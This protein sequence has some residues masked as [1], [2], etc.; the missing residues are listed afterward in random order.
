MPPTKNHWYFGA[1]LAVLLL[2]I[3]AGLR[4]L[5][6]ILLAPVFLSSFGFFVLGGLVYYAIQSDRESQP[7]PASRQRRAIRPLRFTQSAAW[8][9][10]LDGNPT[11]STH[12]PIHPDASPE[13]NNIWNRFLGLIIQHFV[14]PWYDRISPSPAFPYA[15]D[16]VI[17]DAVQEV[18]RRA[19][20]VDWPSVMVSKVLP[21]L[22][23][24][25]QHYRSVEHHT[26]T[27]PLLPLPLPNRPHKAFSD[28]HLSSSAIEE[29][30]RQTLS[31]IVSQAVPEKDQTPVSMT[32]VRE[33]LL[34][35]VVTPMLT[36]ICEADFWNRQIDEH[37][38][39]YLHEQQQVD[40]FLSALS[41]LPAS[42]SS[43][44]L[45]P[46]STRKNRNPASINADSTP[47]Q[48]DVFL[49][50][51]RKLKSLGEARRLRADVERELRV[52]KVAF[53][54]D[55]R[56]VA[57]GYGPKGKDGE[58][59][60]RRNR[61]YVERLEKARMDIDTRIDMLSGDSKQQHH[62]KTVSIE[63]HSDGN[64]TL[65]TILLDPS[66]LAYWLEHM[67]RRQRSRL[68][69]YWLTV[70]GFKDPLEVAGI[71]GPSPDRSSA[72]DTVHE[73]V[74]FLY[75]T[76]FADPSSA[77]IEI[78]P[79]YKEIIEHGA[80]AS[81]LDA[82]EITKIK[83]AIYSSQK[84]VYEQM[85]E[86]DWNTFRKGELFRKAVGDLQRSGFSTKSMSEEKHASRQVSIDNPEP[87]TIP[88][89][90]HTPE[91]KPPRKRQTIPEAS[92]SLL[93]LLP[94]TSNT[95]LASPLP[96]ASRKLG[97]RERNLVPPAPLLSAAAPPSAPSLHLTDVRVAS[98]PP[99]LRSYSDSTQKLS[100][101]KLVGTNVTGR[102]GSAGDVEHLQSQLQHQLQLPYSPSSPRSPSPHHT[103][104]LL[105]S[106]RL[107]SPAMTSAPLDAPLPTARRSSQLDF[108][109]NSAGEEPERSKLFGDDDYDDRENEEDTRRME[110]IQTA[111]S[112]IIADDAGDA[113]TQQTR[114]GKR[115]AFE[116]PAELNERD[117]WSSMILPDNSAKE[118]KIRKTR[119]AEDM[120]DRSSPLSPK[121]PRVV[122]SGE[123]HQPRRRESTLLFDDTLPEDDEVSIS[124]SNDDE[125]S[126]DLFDSSIIPTPGDL[127]LSSTI[128]RLGASLTGLGEQ[129]TL[130][131]SL[132]GRAELTGNQK[133]L[134]ILRR[135]H[136]SV[137]R[138]IRAKEWQKREFTRQEEENRLVPGRTR[139]DI[140]SA[141]VCDDADG[142]ANSAVG[143]GAKQVVR[144]T[145]RVSQVS[146]GQAI[147]GWV[148]TR[149]YN[150]FWEMDKSLR[151]WASARGEIGVIDTLKRVEIPKKRIVGLGSISSGFVESR[152]AALEKYL[153]GLLASSS[154][155]DSYIFRAFISLTP[156]V[157]NGSSSLFNG[158][159]SS[160]AP[161][162]PH[163]VL[164]SLYKTISPGGA[165]DDFNDAT[166][167]TDFMYSG[168][169]R[170]IND[171]GGMVGLGLGYPSS[172]NSD[173]ESVAGAPLGEG[174]TSFTAPICDLFIEMFDLTEKEW[175]RRQAIVIILQQFLGGTIERKV[176]EALRLVTSPSSLGKSL[177]ALQDAL[178]PSG[179]RRPPA[180]PRTE[181]EK[182]ETRS[183]AGK[184]LGLV[185][186]E[187]VAN[188]MGR[189]NA[190]RAAR[191]VF[192]T[193]QDER[194]NQHLVLCVMDVEYAPTIW[195]LTWRVCQ[196]HPAALV[197]Y[198]R[199]ISTKME[200]RAFYD[201]MVNWVNEGADGDWSPSH[202]SDAQRESI[203]YLCLFLVMILVFWQ[204]KIAYW[205]DKKRFR[206]IATG[207]IKEKRVWRTIPVPILWPFKILTVLYHELS[208]AMVG[209]CTIWWKQWSHG[210]PQGYTRGYILFIMVDKYEGGLTAFG[211]DIEP[212]Y[213]LTLPAV[214]AAYSVAGFYLLDVL[215]S[216]HVGISSMSL[217]RSKFGALSLICLTVL[218]VI[219]CMIVRAKSAITH[220][221][222]H[223]RAWCLR[224]IFCNPGKAKSEDE[225][226]EYARETRNQE[227]DYRHEQD[228]EGPT[229]HDLHASQDII[230]ACSV[231]VDILLWAAWNWDD[232]IY[233]RLV[234]LFM[235]LMSALY[236][237]WDIA[238]D[239]IKYAKVAQSDATLMAQAYNKKIEKHNNKHPNHPR[240]MRGTTF[241]A[242][243]WLMA[244]LVLIVAVLVG[245]YFC[246]RLT[247]VE[248]AIESREFLP[249][250]FHYGPA[251]LESDISGVSDAVSGEVSS[252]VAS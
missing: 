25:L 82:S 64:V 47:S 249:A 237:V 13:L 89:S 44:S 116:S 214:A 2:A 195:G 104:R 59:E 150:E 65:Y 168:L 71:D 179:L 199:R 102:K 39:K 236:A 14:L 35:A 250:Q 158:P 238:L 134:K 28:P 243:L 233:L 34:G 231:V 124:P 91:P 248:Q 85:E 37:V 239:G 26:A 121:V 81:K 46:S 234:M 173:V 72:D 95:G 170:Q 222:H 57:A 203:L 216:F 171:I 66:S 115:S 41:S 219:I 131:E 8:A 99:F 224:W 140:P 87:Y 147:P 178:F 7:S 29:H 208:H 19:E 242:S 30:L 61:K 143:L 184:K 74:K 24:H 149:R 125:G 142:A 122:L 73:D 209:M 15:V 196:S 132:I 42:K 246:F 137:R 251:N 172:T 192:G 200:Q 55:A 162:A 226:H 201:P 32:I 58:K 164:K 70:E 48:F 155:C 93:N 23:N 159:L 105:E 153:Q 9:A 1:A 103:P 68:V 10:T 215:E 139:L 151:E 182:S 148:V 185:I 135:S 165:F 245:A 189:G 186:P 197:A 38:G 49:K 154:I 84:E 83:R 183:K 181:E 123:R 228:P 211:G 40:K 78:S 17:R 88:S 161:L 53:T 144:Y 191:R 218:A 107:L 212:N 79:R 120:R 232:S 244:K 77:I 163:N 76:Y 27:S 90:H 43:T 240:A 187:M 112:E 210:V 167:V 31:R 109:I 130:L 5:Q 175:L 12:P 129:S 225:K 136:T 3:F 252:W 194:M 176:R 118:D 128:A 177:S 110:A 247:K 21:V 52:A 206:V 205:W 111:L 241:Y 152:R 156:S 126:S 146:H 221:W 213:T 174:M 113:E 67:E 20:V 69:Q 188:M 235:G 4:L 75:S 157:P 45:A 117:M 220:H 202:P 223:M 145:V 198:N 108:L 180:T 22:T 51:I 63:D 56:K 6:A 92:K 229:E 217:N 100:D 16:G 138:E 60:T 141:V 97:F 18:I 11:D 36:M 62:S 86:E 227:A 54:E 193:L 106:P 133:E 94:R 166:G 114:D 96:G 204:G 33:I 230:I 98:P 127:Q 101:Q 169:S 160:L 50:S 80:L 119:S 207:E 190:R